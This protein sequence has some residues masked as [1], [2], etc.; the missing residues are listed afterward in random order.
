MILCSAENAIG[1]HAYKPDDMLTLHSGKTVEVNNTDCR[2]RLVLADGVSYA[3]LVLGADVVLDAATLR[4]TQMVATGNLHC[5]R[6]EQRRGLE[7]T[8]IA[9][10]RLSGDLVH[11]LPFALEFYKQEFQSPVADMRNSVANRNNA[12]SSCAAQFIYW[13]IESTPVRW[14]HID[15][16]GPAMLKDRGTG[17]GVALLTATVVAYGEI[18]ARAQRSRA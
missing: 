16:A 14:G 9:A 10:G 3:V 5:G 13:H 12:Q 7:R 6:G 11:P 8:L 1:R 17:F 18:L 2:G 15:L 4:G